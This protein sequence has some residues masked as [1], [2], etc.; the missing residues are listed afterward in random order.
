MGSHLRPSRE[1][2]IAIFEKIDFFGWP[3]FW[4]WLAGRDRG[5]GRGHG[6]GRGRGHGRGRGR[7][8][9]RGPRGRPRAPS[10]GMGTVTGKPLPEN[11]PRKIV[12]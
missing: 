1:R 4:G 10:W 8:R 7:G 6:R 2:L 3:L 5:H 9:G 11:R 12:I